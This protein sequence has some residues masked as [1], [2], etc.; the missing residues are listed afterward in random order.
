[1]KIDA[2]PLFSAT[3]ETFRT[4]MDKFL[5]WKS[6]RAGQEIIN[7]EDKNSDLLF[8]TKGK[9]RVVIYTLSGR[10]VTLDDIEA[11]SFFGE[12]AAID[13]EPRSASVIAL[14][15][16]EIAFLPAERFE[17]GLK[18]ESQVALRIMHRMSMIIRHANERIVKLSTLGANNRIHAEILRL[19]R[20]KGIEKDGKIY[21]SPIPVHSDIAARI[22]T[23]RETVARAMSDLAKQGIVTRENGA[24]VVQDVKRLEQMVQDVRGD[25]L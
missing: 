11:G 2:I 18:K 13:K 19:A 14:E 10:E 24:L 15:P 20:K 25:I 9:V 16:S 8:V 4:E 1:M 21:I 22:S 12:M 3:S 17:E 6:F 5:R 7:R 23:V